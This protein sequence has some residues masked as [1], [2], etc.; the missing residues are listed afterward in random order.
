MDLI[1][2]RIELRPGR[3]PPIDRRAL[4]AQCRPD[5]VAIDPKPP[6]EFLDRHPANEVLTPQISSPLHVK[7]ALLP[8]SNNMNEPKFNTLPDASAT[9]RQGGAFSTGQGG[10]AFHR[11]RHTD[12]VV[13]PASLEKTSRHDLLSE[14]DPSP[15]FDLPQPL[16]SKRVSAAKECAADLLP[17]LRWVGRGSV[18][19]THHAVWCKLR[20]IPGR[21]TVRPTSSNRRV[22]Y[23]AI[24]YLI[25]S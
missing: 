2:I 14:P 4:G 25:P 3:R 7:H 9:T 22:A 1:P 23:R 12:V 18:A 13:H 11:R 16:P 24:E 8:D 10:W 15:A 21:P 20:R 19:P 6:R 17:L 5:R